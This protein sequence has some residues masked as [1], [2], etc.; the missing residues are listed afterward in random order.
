MFGE[1]PLGEREPV[2]FIAFNIDERHPENNNLPS[3]N[4]SNRQTSKNRNCM[5]LFFCLSI[6]SLLARANDGFN[7]ILDKTVNPLVCQPFRIS[8]SPQVVVNSHDQITTNPQI[9]TL[10]PFRLSF[11]RP[12]TTLPPHSALKKKNLFFLTPFRSPLSSIIMI[13]RRAT[14]YEA[15]DMSCHCN[16]CIGLQFADKSVIPQVLDKLDRSVYGLHLSYNDGYITRV[17][18]SAP[19]HRLPN[20]IR[21]LH[22]A[23]QWLNQTHPLVF[24]ERLASLGYNDT[25]VILNITHSY[26]DGGYFRYLIDHLFDPAPGDLPALPPILQDRLPNEFAAA[27]NVAVPWTFDPYL[28]RFSTRHA[29][30]ANPSQFIKYET[31]RFRA[32][33]LQCFNRET[34]RFENVGDHIWLSELLAIAVH[35]GKLPDLSGISTCVDTRSHFKT[36]PSGYTL[37]KCFTQVTASTPLSPRQTLR[38]VG[39]GMRA[40]L[41][42]RRGILEDIARIK[43]DDSK[44]VGKPFPGIVLEVSN[45][46]PIALKWPIVDAWTGLSMHSQFTGDGVS[47][48][49]FSVEREKVKE[50]VLRFRY[51]D[52]RLGDDEACA[53]AKSLEHCMKHISLDRTVQSAFDEL[54]D[55]HSVKPK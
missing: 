46:G 50:L 38:Q 17:P 41:I 29:T 30:F 12:P 4:R 27:Q 21:D 11:F 6:V 36:L 35:S 51:S 7:A 16:I 9:S 20:D 31:L 39:N 10:P 13:R 32:E 2:E 26:A 43:F 42:R 55:L 25:K 22:R 3:T 37:L 52:G 19:R 40:D 48:M 45:M 18:A 14:S 5:A 34:R 33:D 53:I 1:F 28:T 15:M 54:Q 44:P 8:L 49:S 24:S 47:V 23:S